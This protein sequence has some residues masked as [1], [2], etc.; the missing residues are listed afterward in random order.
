MITINLPYP[1]S[2]NRIWRRVGNHTILSA[3]G[4]IYRKTVG[5][6]CLI[7]RIVGRRFDCRLSVVMEVNPPDNRKRDL[8]N[9]PKAV[10]DALTHAGV[11][12]DDSL[13]DEMIVRR[14]QII[15]D[16]AITITIQEAA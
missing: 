4:R 8:D 10:F 15:K 12:M 14:K 5:D 11:W 7:N 2:A 16:G 9:L 6:I 13:I 3:E 1:P